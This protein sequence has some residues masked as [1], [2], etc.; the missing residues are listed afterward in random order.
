M[1]RI[2]HG[3]KK[4]GKKLALNDISF[5]VGPGKIIS[6]ISPNGSGKSTLLRILGALD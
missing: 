6:L 4:Y 3:T 1:I 2:S 5:N